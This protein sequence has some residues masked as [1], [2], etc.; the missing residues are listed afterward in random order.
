MPL[1]DYITYEQGFA[2]SEFRTHFAETFPRLLPSLRK[3]I[4]G[5]TRNEELLCLFIILHT[6][7]QRISHLR[8]ISRSSLNMARHRLREKMG[9]KT[10]ESLEE[11]IRK[12]FRE[13]GYTEFN[14]ND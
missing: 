14:I 5:I 9:L 8:H 10:S 7:S 3:R 1:M 11:T 2:E 4:P 12:M 6:D 13:C